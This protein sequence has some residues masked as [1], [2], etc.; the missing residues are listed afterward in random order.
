MGLKASFTSCPLSTTDVDGSSLFSVLLLDNH[1]RA[2]GAIEDCQEGQSFESSLKQY[3]QQSVLK[4][5]TMSSEQQQHDGQPRET[6]VGSL[7]T[8]TTTASPPMMD[9]PES[10]ASSLDH[11]LLESIFY[12]EMIQMDDSM[13]LISSSL[14]STLAADGSVR[15]QQ[16]SDNASL[17]LSIDSAASHLHHDPHT[18]ST[19]SGVPYSHHEAPQAQQPY[20]NDHTEAI[21]GQSHLPS[22]GQAPLHLPETAGSTMATMATSLAS[23]TPSSNHSHSLPVHGINGSTAAAAAAAPADLLTQQHSQSSGGNNSNPETDEDKRKKLVSQFAALASRLGIRLPEEVVSSLTSQP[24]ENHGAVLQQALGAMGATVTTTTPS[25]SPTN[26]TSAQQPP[27]AS[28]ATTSVQQL[29]QAADAAVAAAS[30]KRVAQAA[31]EADH[32]D[33]TSNNNNSNKQA[34]YSKRRKKPRLSD[35]EAKLAE[36]QSENS[37]LKRHLANLSSQTQ[38]LEEERLKQEARMRNMLDQGATDTELDN[39]VKHFQEMYSD[40]GRRRHQELHFHLDQLQR[41]ANPTNFTKLGLWTMGQQSSNSRNPIAGILQKELN[42]STQQGKKI[43]E[44]RKRIQDIC[45]NLKECLA[46][47]ANLKTLCAE[48]TQTF[49]DR[50][51]KC[52]EILTPKQVVKLIIWINENTEMLESVCPG[53]GSENIS[54][55]VKKLPN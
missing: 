46:L 45:S 50:L 10:G 34:P 17:S 4:N 23:T 52:R 14:L 8:N 2:R 21:A 18:D 40:Y 19:I 41:L 15:Q 44:K 30:R 54:G 47:L 31:A 38:H 22:S 20:P 51:S 24:G 37:M 29:A 26:S 27:K 9:E 25:V 6:S 5:C 39:E 16:Q 11:A 1:E 3:F 7:T 36:L 33:G 35:C 43:L 13:S 32:S 48:K 55:S 42:I 12:N 53:W 28:T 49:H